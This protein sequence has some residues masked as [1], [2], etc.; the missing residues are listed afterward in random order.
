M[1]RVELG[2]VFGSAL[3][4][5]RRSIAVSERLKIMG[6]GSFR[7]GYTAGVFDLF[8]IG[9]VNLLR[10]ARSLCD[11][12]IVGV[13]TDECCRLSAK[14]KVPI[15]PFHERI[16]VV[17][18]CRFVD[19][20]VPQSNLDKVEAQMRLKFNLLFVGDDWYLTDSWKDFEGQLAEQ[21]VDVIYFPYTEGQSSTKINEVLRR[22]R[23]VSIDEVGEAV[24]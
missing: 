14:E 13:S 10:N 16:E 23:L 17:R 21:A 3:V 9:H 6:Q 7:I 22:E 19:A 24:R 2:A 4:G 1:V 12:L 18:S 11:R 20:V 5:H 15:I 8:H